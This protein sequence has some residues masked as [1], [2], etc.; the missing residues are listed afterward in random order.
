[1]GLFFVLMCTFFAMV[2]PAGGDGWLGGWSS[3]EQ[4]W[5]EEEDVH[6]FRRLIN[7]MAHDDL[8]AI[9][10]LPAIIAARKRKIECGLHGHFPL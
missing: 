10:D 4:T 2:G 9:E 3:S 1:M 5:V 8:G 6:I 7:V